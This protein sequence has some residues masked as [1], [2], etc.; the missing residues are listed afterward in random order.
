MLHYAGIGADATWFFGKMT[1]VNYDYIGLSYYPIWHGKSIADLKL[2]INSLDQT[3]G[4]KVLVA[5][6]SYPFTLG[7]N[8]FTNNI[9]G[10]NDQIIPA[11][12]ASPQGQKNYLLALK[13]MLQETQNG[14]GFYYWGAEWISFKGN[15]ATNGSPW[16][17]RA[18]YDFSN[19]ALPAMDVFLP[20]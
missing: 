16:E 10:S 20:Y 13:T 19:K 14:I 9:V 6:T 3:Y 17:N 7:F 12:E 5:E 1:A 15:Q 18:L 11:F 2:T 8:D 4:K